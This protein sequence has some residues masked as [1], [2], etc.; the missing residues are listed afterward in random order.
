VVKLSTLEEGFANIE[1]QV[2]DQGIGMTEKH[3]QG[4]FKPFHQVNTEESRRFNPNG[5]GLGLSIC[6]NIAACLNGDLTVESEWGI[7]SR[8]TFKV[9]TEI[10][11]WKKTKEKEMAN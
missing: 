7:G 8:F 1:I 4:V 3:L 5:N 9:K 10:A 6:K 11:D 2:T